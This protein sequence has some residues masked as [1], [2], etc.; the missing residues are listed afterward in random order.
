MTSRN[1]LIFLYR[2]SR[3]AYGSTTMR[4]HQ[5]SQCV[6]PHLPETNVRLQA[7]SRH[8]LFQTLWARM[9]PHGSTIFATKGVVRILCAEAVH[10]L[11]KRGCTVLA[12][13]VDLPNE[14]L[15]GPELGVDCLISPS[16]S[17]V[18]RLQAHVDAHWGGGARPLV[19]PLLHNADQRLYG[20]KIR[21]L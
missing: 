15:P 14:E 11:H 7:F 3:I 16:F 13:V 17:G 2:K 6:A 18:A 19:S 20:R 10:I 8:E 1:H 4:A 21:S 5:L 12:D 9:V